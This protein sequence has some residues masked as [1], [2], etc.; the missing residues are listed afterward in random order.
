MDGWGDTTSWTAT[1]SIWVP[2]SFPSFT[3][4]DEIHFGAG[5]EEP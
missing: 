1:A 4:D 3:A 2:V 5:H